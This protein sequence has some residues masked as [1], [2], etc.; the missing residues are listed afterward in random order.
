MRPEGA[1]A[2]EWLKLNST[3]KFE[4]IGKSFATKK[5]GTIILNICT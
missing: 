5:K 3:G 1:Q 2:I 4:R